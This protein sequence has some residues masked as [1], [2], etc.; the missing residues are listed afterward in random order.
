MQ[1]GLDEEDTAKQ[2]LSQLDDMDPIV[3]E[4]LEKLARLKRDVLV[5]AEHEEREEFPA[6]RVSYDADRLQKMATSVQAAEAAAPT[7]PHPGVDSATVNLIAGPFAAIVGRIRD[8]MEQR[9]S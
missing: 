3:P 9:R 5:H 8:R 7:R 6:L 2:D 4:F 1:A